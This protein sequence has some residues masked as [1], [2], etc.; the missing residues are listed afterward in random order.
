MLGIPMAVDG[1]GDGDNSCT[2]EKFLQSPDLAGL[3]RTN[4]TQQ[5]HATSK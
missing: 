4:T 5:R 2:F 1:D 3:L